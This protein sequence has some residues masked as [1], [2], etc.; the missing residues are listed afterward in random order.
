MRLPLKLAESWFLG[1]LNSHVCNSFI[2]VVITFEM[3]L[4]D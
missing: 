4:L 2:L 3:D 1:S